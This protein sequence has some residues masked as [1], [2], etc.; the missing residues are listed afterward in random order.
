MSWVAN[1]I[2]AQPQ[3][4]VM[5]SLAREPFLANQM[6]HINDLE[7][8]RFQWVRDRFFTDDPPTEI[9]HGVPEGGLLAVSPHLYSNG[10]SVKDPPPKEF[11]ELFFE[12]RPSHGHPP[13]EK[14]S[15]ISPADSPDVLLPPDFDES[16]YPLSLQ[17]FL[18]SVALKTGTPVTYYWSSMWGGDVEE[19]IGWAFDSSDHVYQ[20]VDNESALVHSADG[21]RTEKDRGVLQ[22]L[23]AHLG[24]DLPTGFFALHEGSFDWKRYWLR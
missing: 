13:S 9:R 8:I 24:L 1:Q 14:W 4:M 20:F 2:Y 15:S 6:F 18:K 22:M 12:G 10:Y 3:A 23:L 5:E 19:E 16:Y 21:Q 17:R 11:C 7:G